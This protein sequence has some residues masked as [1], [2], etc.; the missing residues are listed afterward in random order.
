MI[1]FLAPP[2]RPATVALAVSFFEAVL[3]RQLP[4]VPAAVAAVAVG[5]IGETEESDKS[6]D[7]LGGSGVV[8]GIEGEE[9]DVEVVPVAVGCTSYLKMSSLLTLL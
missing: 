5:V 7:A 2:R 1:S 9:A 8:E 6:M 4:A 3:F